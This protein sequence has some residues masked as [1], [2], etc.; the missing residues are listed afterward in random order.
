[1]YDHAGEEAREYLIREFGWRFEGDAQSWPIIVQDSGSSTPDDIQLEWPIQ[2]VIMADDGVVHLVRGFDPGTDLLDLSAFASGME[3]ITISNQLRSDGSVRWIEIADR[4]GET[5]LVLRFDA[6]TPLDASA[7][8][9]DD[10]IFAD[11][12]LA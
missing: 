2:T 1:M 11:V 10:F 6:D 5:E 9:T 3:D 8:T 7:L 4:T 12:F